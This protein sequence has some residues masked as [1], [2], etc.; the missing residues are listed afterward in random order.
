MSR[1]KVAFFTVS[2][3]R[4]GAERVVANLCNYLCDKYEVHLLLC[5][6]V[7]DYKL[8]NRI[9]VSF[10]SDGKDISAEIGKLLVM[11][12]YARK[13]RYW[14]EEH[15][16]NIF[17]SFLFRPNVIAALAKKSNSKLVKVV[18]S[19]RSNPW[20]QYKGKGIKGLVN[21][22]LIRNVYPDADRI[23][24][25][26]FGSKYALQH[27]YHIEKEKIDIIR[28]P[29][30]TAFQS[31]NGQRSGSN[32]VYVSVGRMDDGKNHIMQIRAFA[33]MLAIDPRK[34]AELWLIGEGPLKY[35]LKQ[36]TE[37]L[38]ILPFVQFLGYRG[39][40]EQILQQCDV[41][42]FS[43]QRE[44]FPNVLLE[45]MAVGLPVISTDCEYGPR[46]IIT[47][48]D[49]L[50]DSNLEGVE[51]GKYGILLPCNNVEYLTEAMTML[52]RNDDLKKELTHNYAEL[53]RGYQIESIAQQYEQ[54]IAEM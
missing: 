21:R 49:A 53:L 51:I 14:L 27:Y 5:E 7:I 32:F 10:I 35:H 29:I 9:L 47:D 1:K 24:V 34:E 25:N 40:V 38:G 6:N 42:V 2:M 28:N 45:A 37:R 41:F 50:P 36:E 15:K 13:L 39:D 17:F 16:V 11:P 4:G 30:S 48:Q 43:S 8:D 33:A 22:F 54:I 3:R 26:S 44:G 20:L 18:I 23:T 52:Y 46:E 12:F 31:N 19:E